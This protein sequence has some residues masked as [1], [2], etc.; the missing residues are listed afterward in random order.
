M[1]NKPAPKGIDLEMLILGSMITDEVIAEEAFCFLQ[2]EDFT[3]PTYA[4]IFITM[5]TLMQDR[6]EINAVS[7]AAKMPVENIED[8]LRDLVKTAQSIMDY[9]VS[10]ED[11][12]DF[13]KEQIYNLLSAKNYVSSAQ[14]LETMLQSIR[15]GRQA[16]SSGLEEFDYRAGGLQ[17]GSLC[18]LGGRPSQGKTAFALNLALNAV[19]KDECA[20]FFSLQHNSRRVFE[21]MACAA[22]EVNL[23]DLMGGRLSEADKLKLEQTYRDM[24]SK[25][26]FIEDSVNLKIGDICAKSRA[27]AREREEELNKKLNIVIVDGLSAINTDGILRLKELAR[28]LDVAVIITLNMPRAK[29]CRGGGYRPQREEL[30]NTGAMEYADLVCFVHREYYYRRTE[31]SLKNRATIILA[32]NGEGC[33]GD[34]DLYFDADTGRITTPE[35]RAN[36]D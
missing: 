4:Q 28:A 23:F 24:A 8:I 18:V 12:Y 6:E 19:L 30:L 36:C 34:I 32:K 7:V 10:S 2:G 5:H 35:V 27:F 26:L 11:I 29:H 33:L 13:I 1:K 14:M 31:E 3:I 9:C 21:R 22:A 25:K 20:L 15:E 16:I 17:R